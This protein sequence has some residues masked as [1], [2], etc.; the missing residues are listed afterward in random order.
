MSCRIC[1]GKLKKIINLGK[2]G[3]V[4]SFYRKKSKS[5]KFKISLNFCVKCKHVQINEKLN[6]D[7]LFRNYLWETGISKSNISLIKNFI[8]SFKK[9]KMKKEKNKIF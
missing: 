1:K 2:I 9:F 7:L 8:K 3:L 5:K 6:P 4:G